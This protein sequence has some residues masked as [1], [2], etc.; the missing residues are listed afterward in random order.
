MT[1]PALELVATVLADVGEPLEVG[2]LATG[3]RRVVPIT[4]G[5]VS[6][7]LLTGR[8]LP[9]GADVQLLRSDT[10]TELEARYLLES[11]A[12]ELVSVHN[13][14]LRVASV[15]D[16]AHL[17]RGEPVDP[18]RVYFRG[19]VRLETAAPRLA[20]L[21]SHLYLGVGTR[22]PRGVRIELFEVQ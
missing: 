7:P 19:A 16:S 11:D 13:S 12:G 9:G 15:E 18:A 5:T 10:E 21:N 17:R 20:R 4:G 14:A 22:Y 6:G 1:A 2:A 8:V 3:V